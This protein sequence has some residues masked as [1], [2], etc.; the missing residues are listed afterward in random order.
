MD[1]I[2]VS[3]CGIDMIQDKDDVGEGEGLSQDREV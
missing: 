2:Q 3:C 1:Y